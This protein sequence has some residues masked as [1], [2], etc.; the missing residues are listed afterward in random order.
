[1][2][3]Q[4]KQTRKTAQQRQP[5]AEPLQLLSR[6][7]LGEFHDVVERTPHG[8]HLVLEEP[9]VPREHAMNHVEKRLH[10][11][12]G[13]RKT[14]E[15]GEEEQE[16][17]ENNRGADGEQVREPLGDALPQ[18]PHEEHER[19]VERDLLVA[20]RHDEEKGAQ[21][22]PVARNAHNGQKNEA[23]AHR[24][25]LEVGVIHQQKGRREEEKGEH[26]RSTLGKSRTITCVR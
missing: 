23:K 18:Q 26:L 24:V 8:R 9:A 5:S 12:E 13:G 6:E 1:M 4:K 14:Q 2:P 16:E 17:G 3:P 19:V 7:E 25:V 20:D 15:E 22:V 10:G 11:R 21:T